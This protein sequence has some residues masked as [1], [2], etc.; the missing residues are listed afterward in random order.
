MHAY[1]LEELAI[2][3]D[4]VKTEYYCGVYRGVLDTIEIKISHEGVIATSY[5][6]TRRI[7]KKLN[8]HDVHAIEIRI[9]TT[10][11]HPVKFEGV[12][13]DLHFCPVVFNEGE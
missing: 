11:G 3:T 2:L 1:F 7:Y 9:I 5:V 4:I 8:S 12:E 10:D 13:L 6:P